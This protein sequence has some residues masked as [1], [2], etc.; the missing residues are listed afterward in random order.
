MAWNYRNRR[1]YYRRRYYRRG[2]GSRSGRRAYGNMK[3]AK[4]QAD[5]A[6]F[7]INVPSKITSFMKSN[8]TL[9]G[10]VNETR[11]TGVY[12]ISIYDLLRRSEFF[13]NYANMYDEFKIDKIKVKLLPTAFTINTNGSYRNLTVY[14]AWDRT[15]LNSTQLYANIDK[16]TP[17]NNKIYCTVG[18]D[19]TTYSSA[20]SRTV[21]PN[22]NTSI[23]RWLNPKTITEKSQ[24]L[25]TA[26]LKKWYNGYSEVDGCFTGIDFSG[27]EVD[28]AN[29]ST[30]LNDLNAVI[31]YS[32]CAK[33]NPC[34]LLEDPSIKFKP[35]L[36][37]GVFPPVDATTFNENTNLIHFNVETEIVCTYRGLR[38]ARVVN[39][40]TQ[41]GGDQPQ[42]IIVPKATPIQANGTYYAAR[43]G[44]NGWSSVVVE[45]PTDGDQPELER[46]VLEVELNDAVV[47]AARR[48][49]DTD[50][51]GQPLTNIIEWPPIGAI[52]WKNGALETV[53]NA[54]AKWVDGATINVTGL[55]LASEF[56]QTTDIVLNNVLVTRSAQAEPETARYP[57][58][59]NF[60]ESFDIKFRNNPANHT[61]VH[62]EN[63]DPVRGVNIIRSPLYI[64]D[65]SQYPEDDTPAKQI[66]RNPLINPGENH[67]AWFTVDSEQKPWLNFVF[68][69]PDGHNSKVVNPGTDMQDDVVLPVLYANYITGKA[70][71]P[72]IGN[73]NLTQNGTY[74]IGN[75][76]GDQNTIEVEQVNSNGTT[77][78]TK[79][80]S[81]PTSLQVKRLRD[82]ETEEDIIVPNNN[83]IFSL[84]TIG[85]DIAKTFEINTVKMIETQINPDPSAEPDESIIKTNYTEALNWT[86]TAPGQHR[87]EQFVYNDPS[88][89]G[90]WFCI[91]YTNGYYGVFTF[92]C[93]E[94][95]VNVDI[96]NNK[97]TGNIASAFIQYQ[98][99]FEGQEFSDD[100]FL[101]S[102]GTST[103]ASDPSKFESVL[104]ININIKNIDHMRTAG[105]GSI[106]LWIGNGT[107]PDTGKDMDWDLPTSST[108]FTYNYNTEIYKFNG[109]ETQENDPQN[110]KGLVKKSHF[111]KLR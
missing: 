110:T 50:P 8:T 98:G 103:D 20:E 96:F 106:Q 75:F 22:T 91:Y 3:A 15:G 80:K 4:Q 45:V 42:Q 21:N 60:S 33:D 70:P 40:S 35:T 38:K 43:E 101:D 92:D 82:G 9:P 90:L 107:D 31:R 61:L 5:N 63:N 13:N 57:E 28:L 67:G 83:A 36:L 104:P 2:Y 18:E 77:Q 52:D 26:L 6:T 48:R 69:L 84:G 14:T 44:V 25:S 100:L 99:T 64:G 24:W 30:Q 10:L 65:I 66:A 19:I 47:E 111:T 32:A 79:F 46:N 105:G 72:L 102:F 71:A 94:E 53:P 93:Y 11:T 58:D 95:T 41:G 76:V 89:A 7:T 16:I 68:Q 49:N 97:G 29:I 109:V 54:D 86:T 56:T 27:D 59:F 1:R 85:V 12:P 74:A 88:Q 87:Q 39:S 23:T 78:T 62:V 108:N 17:A 37:V 55:N 51:T 81:L 73:F 34:F